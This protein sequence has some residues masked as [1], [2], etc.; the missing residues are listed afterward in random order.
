MLGSGVRLRVHAYNLAD[1]VRGLING[2]K[3]SQN[4]PC[5]TAAAAAAM[6]LRTRKMAHTK[7]P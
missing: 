6:A 2:R 3:S 5:W 4:P 7:P 1:D